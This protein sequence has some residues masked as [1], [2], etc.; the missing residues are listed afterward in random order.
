[1]PE[2]FSVKLAGPAGS[3]IMS[4]GEILFRA[5][6]TAGY[7][8]QGYPE[9]PSLIKGG[10]NIYLITLSQKPFPSNANR[11]DL[12][13]ALT[14]TALD[15]EHRYIENFTHVVAD[16]GLKADHTHKLLHQPALLEVAKSAGN[17]LTLNTAMIGFAS[18][19]LKLEADLV[20]SL[21]KEELGGKSQ[22]LL[23][24]NKTAFDKARELSTQFHLDLTLPGKTNTDHKLCLS[25]TEGTGL[26]AIA[27][28]IN[29]Y[30]GYPMTPSSPLLHFMAAHQ[31]EFNFLVRQTEDEL[32]AINMVVGA[33][34]AGA[35]SMTGTSGG[36]FALMEEGISLAGM[37]ETPVVI[38]LAQRPA[39]ATG[40]PTWTSQADL[41]FAINAGHGEFPKIVLAPSDPVDCYRLIHHA[42]SL[43]QTFHC[44]VIV[45]SDKYLAENKYACPNLPPLDPVPL[46]AAL[47]SPKGDEMYSRYGYTP[48]GVHPRTLPG[49]PGG[50]YVA[51]SDEH[52]PTGLVDES[53]ETRAANNQR[54]LHKIA[55]I[56][57]HLPLPEVYG[58]GEKALLTWGSHKHIG[59]Q[60]AEKL[61]LV[62]IHFTYLWPLPD[63][64][65]KILSGYHQIVTAENNETHQLARLLRQE[66]GV[67][68][69]IAT[70]DD[71]GRPLDPDKL[72]DQIKNA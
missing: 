61:K 59:R 67:K 43:S 41:M 29:F 2:I 33:S 35:K 49:M 23:D 68:V 12:L 8:A 11:V 3:G 26:G 71:S 56:K 5:L 9:Y 15:N 64:L 19:Q 70:G 36:G 57:R 51:N 50:E 17:P 53:A 4:A 58:S 34:F 13:L 7:Y 24:Q 47:P 65:E 72:I 39:P 55:E 14:Q 66:I 6:V 10:H 54:R 22:T 44:P 30:A 21:I 45:L 63:G 25:G 27:A 60:V 16:I 20:W 46:S 62:H 38:Y 28:G 31:T 52:G 18:H 40:L 48:D 32:A 69:D 42:F 37:L 1:M